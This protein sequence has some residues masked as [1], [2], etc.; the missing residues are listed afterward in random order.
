MAP[1]ERGNSRGRHYFG[2][3]R[4]GLRA[5]STLHRIIYRLSGGRLGVRLTRTAPTLLLTTIGRKTGRSRTV[6]LIYLADGERLIVVGSM[7]GAATHPAWWRN[8]RAQ[9]EAWVEVAGR[10]WAVRAE[11]A[12]GDERERLWGRLLAIFPGF[13][14]YQRATNRSI[15]VVILRKWS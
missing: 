12:R 7:G 1:R 11:E 8:L 10:R 13:A 15:P 3:L 14:A 4:P 9:P 5:F 6:P 2:L